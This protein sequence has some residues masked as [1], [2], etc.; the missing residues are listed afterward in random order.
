MTTQSRSDKITRLLRLCAL[1][2]DPRGDW[3]SLQREMG[4]TRYALRNWMK[5][6]RV[7]RV[8]AEWLQHRFPHLVP[9]ANELQG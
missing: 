5:E 3:K 7:P 6:G 9:D 2:V 4:V 8:K 1:E